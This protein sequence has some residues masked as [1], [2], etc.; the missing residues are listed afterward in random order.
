MDT[1]K[2]IDALIE[3]AGRDASAF[4]EKNPDDVPTE[5]W[6]ENSYTA[7]LPL[8]KDDI[9]VDPGPGPHPQLFAAYRGAINQHLGERVS[10]RDA[11][12]D[13]TQQPTPG[14]N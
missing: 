1:Q 11:A 7:A 4:R 14:E 6:I 3:R 10:T 12:A 9:G 2:L 13:L 8:A 5:R